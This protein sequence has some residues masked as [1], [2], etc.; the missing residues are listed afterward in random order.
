MA[1]RW[2]VQYFYDEARTTLSL[3]D[4][5]FPSAQHGIAVGTIYDQLNQSGNP[6]FTAL[7]SSDGGAHWSLE[8]IKDRPRSLFFLDESRGWMVADNG[9][10]F[11]EESGRNWAKI[12]EQKKPNHKFGATP[13]GGI[14]E[15]V[16]FLDPQHG[17]A[18]GLQKTVLE[19]H[20]GGHTWTPV[21]EAAK[22]QANPSFTSYT[23]IAFDG[24]KFGMIVGQAIPPRRDD[25]HRL[26]SWLDPE[27]AAKREQVPNLTLVLQTRDGGATWNSSTAP[28]F[29]E[30]ASLRLAG[31]NGLNVMAFDEGF[32]WPSEVY[33][34]NL[35]TGDTTR[36]FREKD[37]RVWDSALFAGPRAFLATVEPSGRL[38]T[39]PIPGKV[40]M[41]TSTNLTDWSEMKVDYKAVARWLVLAGPDAD[42][43]WA[44]TDTGMILHLEPD[45]TTSHSR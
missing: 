15:R 31:T 38:N 27:K 21:A 18:V 39:T 4:L 30:V 34:L 7:I 1:Q 24:P 22:P 2:T 45:L 10:W 16:W 32:E 5:A 33:H 40:R 42:H 9:I 41:L 37:R 36:V 3:E 8:P 26:P 11:T 29:G 20:D 23:R 25:A 35:S 19:T 43:L 6:K 17:F 12:S 14:I 13:P 44:A 28:L